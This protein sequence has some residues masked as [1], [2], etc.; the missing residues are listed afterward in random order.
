MG[1][2]IAC[3][4]Q[5]ALAR[6]V[7]DPVLIL[8]ADMP[9]VKPT[10]IRALIE[11]VAPDDAVVLPTYGGA[12]GHPVRFPAR[13]LPPLARLAGERGARALLQAAPT[14]RIPTDDGGV[15]R[16]VDVPADLAPTDLA[17][18]DVEPTDP[19]TTS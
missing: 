4:A 7:V 16:D 11:I 15:V 19:D 10:T 17:P 6:G 3:A 2:S 13:L 9:W 18:T 12:D 1:N 8:P 5:A 14:L